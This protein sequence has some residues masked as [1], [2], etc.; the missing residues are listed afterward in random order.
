MG[1]ETVLNNTYRN[2]L[3]LPPCDDQKTSKPKSKQQKRIKWSEECISICLLNKDKCSLLKIIKLP[4]NPSSN[5]LHSRRIM[6]STRESSRESSTP[7]QTV[8]IGFCLRVAGSPN[9]R[10]RI[11]D[12]RPRRAEKQQWTFGRNHWRKKSKSTS[13][14]SNA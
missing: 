13:D 14:S 12:C 11:S 5:S 6:S 2:S 7:S 8:L 3:S 9:S 1:V 10:L 4:R